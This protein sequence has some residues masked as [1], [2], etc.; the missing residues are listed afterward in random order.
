M[1]D[2]YE[3]AITQVFLDE[4]GY[5]NDPHD[6]GG[7]TNWGIT[8]YDA[9]QYW[10]SDATAE[11]VRDMPKQVAEDIYRRHYANIIRY[12]NLPPGVDYAVLDFAINSGIHKSV[13][14]L[15]RILGVAQDGVLGPVTLQWTVK[16]DPTFI[17]NNIY[18]DR[19]AF[20]KSLD[21]WKDFGHGWFTRCT[22][23]H[24]LALSLAKQYS[25]KIATEPS[26]LDIIEGVAESLIKGEI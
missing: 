4:G 12:D 16:N 20:L 1:K 23:G 9:R 2:T 10:K 14:I 5:T 6:S 3:Q 26:T 7:P 18:I 8:I 19:L 24:V 25:T 13:T 17:I 11:D 15:Q 21:T 22:H